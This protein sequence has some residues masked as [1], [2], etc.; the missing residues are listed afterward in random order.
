MA[1]STTP[2]A[3]PSPNDVVYATD[4]ADSVVRKFDLEGNLRMTL[5]SP[6]VTTDTGY[7]QR[8]GPYKVHHNETVLRAGGAVQ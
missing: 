2:T 4:N 1:C 7:G 6:G 5:G 8:R 3:S